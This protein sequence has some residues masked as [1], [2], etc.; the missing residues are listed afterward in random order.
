[1]RSS[2][3]ILP[4][5]VGRADLVRAGLDTETEN[6]HIA[7]WFGFEYRQQTA[8]AT[9][10]P[11]SS[12]KHRPTRA[13]VSRPNT[14]PTPERADKVIAATRIT[15]RKDPDAAP[16]PPPQNLGA[17]AWG[18]RPT[19]PPKFHA[20]T[21]GRR[22]GQLVERILNV[23]S[24]RGRPDMVRIVRRIA[25]ARPLI[26]LPRAQTVSRAETL[27]I[28]VDRS[29]RLTPLWK[30]QSLVVGQIRKLFPDTKLM[31]WVYEEASGAL[32]P[33]KPDW[34]PEPDPKRGPLLVLGDL[35]L[36]AEP[37]QIA[38]WRALARHF[39][40][41]GGT[42]SALVPVP[43]DQVPVALVGPYKID[44]W[45]E[46]AA[47]NRAPDGVEQLMTLASAA[48]R[49]EPGLLR[50]IRLSAYPAAS[51]ADEVGVWQHGALASR[52]VEA[53]S[54]D[55]GQRADYL[56][57]L[58]GLLDT[59]HEAVKRTI[60]EVRNWRQRGADEIW[61]EELLGLP[62]IIREDPEMVDTNDLAAADAFFANMHA[63]ALENGLKTG[64]QAWLS[65]VGRRQRTRDGLWQH[66]HAA[67]A[68]MSVLKN[69]PS[70]VPPVIVDT[71]KRKD[72]WHANVALESGNALTISDGTGMGQHLGTIFMHSEDVEIVTPGNDK[73]VSHAAVSR[74]GGTRI[75]GF[76]L[77]AVLKS[78]YSR[79]EINRLD[80]FH[81]PWAERIG[82]D[83]HGPYADCLGKAQLRF[84]WV[85]PGRGIV[86]PLGGEPQ[87]NTTGR[88]EEAI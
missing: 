7:R 81:V 12:G 30:D 72:G 62:Q 11:A 73:L 52:S 5:L 18:N 66:P 10:V 77:P 67:A 84:R 39:V 4:A 48:V 14:A 54:F 23:A 64:Q 71:P 25:Q 53:A 41:D 70:F 79:M 50:G 46:E 51:V 36:L 63:S 83:A 78:A 16:Q 33:V 2:A 58:P 80:P 56:R 59:H 19:T 27:Q 24:Q 37:E 76:P 3:R 8:D 35:G 29:T 40:F 44:A 69:D 42:A 68:L 86:G 60:A 57:R 38:W 61:Y 17:A 26:D 32:H 74:R 15:T 87:G 34:P 82:R 1:M 31:I 85:P 49:L 9:S 28:V 55:A 65:R 21:S 75:G 13:P 22:I 47:G 6:R 43:V 20:L 45:E 88:R